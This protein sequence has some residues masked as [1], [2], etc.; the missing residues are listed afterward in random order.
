M[1]NKITATGCLI[2]LWRYD[3]RGNVL[4]CVSSPV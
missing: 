1:D 4:L 3:F 2:N